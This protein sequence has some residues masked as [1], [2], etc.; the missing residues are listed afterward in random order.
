M[1][2][3]QLAQRGI[4]GPKNFLEGIYGYFHLYGKNKVSKEALVGELGDRFEM[5]KLIFKRYPSCGGTMASTDAILDLVREKEFLPEDVVQ[6][7][8]KV[9][10]PM[11]KLVG[12]Q[13]EIRD[14]PRVDAQFSIQYCVANAVLRKSS[15]LHHFE[16]SYVREPEIINLIKKIHVTPDPA[17]DKRGRTAVDMQVKIKQGVVHHKSVDIPRGFAGNPLTNQEHAKRLRDCI[18]Y[19]G[20]PLPRGN[21]DKLIWSVNKL[22]EVEDVRSLIPL[23]LTNKG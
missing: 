4:T 12:Q 10:P 22:E 20:K 17:L 8:I 13:F 23:L 21:I 2:C 7:D 18:S 5:T 6:I 11:Y 15:E 1:I 16:D 14:N 19:A 3:T 9:T